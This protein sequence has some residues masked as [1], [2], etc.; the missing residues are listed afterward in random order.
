MRSKLVGC[1]MEGSTYCWLKPYLTL[2]T[3]KPPY[4]QFSKSLKLSMTR[5]QSWFLEQSLIKV[6]EHYLVKQGKHSLSVS[7]IQNHYGKKYYM[8]LMKTFGF[9]TSCSLTRCSLNN[10]SF[11]SLGLNCALGA[12]DMRPFIEAISESNEGFVLCYPNAGNRERI[13]CKRN[14]KEVL[15]TSNSF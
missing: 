15:C 4:L 11:H 9:F 10:L 13:Y 2:P 3:A 1:W 8:T 14:I 7:H 12:K 6:G 5:F